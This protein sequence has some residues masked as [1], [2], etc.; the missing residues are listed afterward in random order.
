[1]RLD[2]FLPAYDFHELHE[3]RVRA[4]ASRIFRAIKVLKAADV[5]LMGMLLAIRSL[6]AW[7]MGGSAMELAGERGVL[8][9]FIG[10]GFL[11][12]AEERD[13]EIVVGRI[14]QFWKPV[15]EESPRIANPPEFVAFARPGFAKA[16]V[17]FRIEERGDGTA[18]VSTETRIAATDPVARRK[19]G[20]Y[21]TVIY[22]GSALIRREW[23]RA[24]KRHAER[25]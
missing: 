8:E 24:I 3:V 2:S 13:H 22:P 6:P 5:P 1:M 19:F 17:N 16:A 9:Q 18:R 11:L 20:A 14:G 23:L 25:G 12:L 7:I 10:A 15:G 21:W 4:P